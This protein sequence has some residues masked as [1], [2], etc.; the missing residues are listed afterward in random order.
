V[1]IECANDSK[2]KSHTKSNGEMHA[3]NNY[4]RQEDKLMDSRT[5]KVRKYN[6]YYEEDEVEMDR[7]RN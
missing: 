4:E 5:N 1:D 3:G 7:S 6:Q 2:I